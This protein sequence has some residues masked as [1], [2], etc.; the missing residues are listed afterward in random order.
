M[1]RKTLLA[2][3][4]TLCASGQAFAASLDQPLPL[5]GP[6]PDAATIQAWQDR[7]FGMFIH[8][9]IFS[10]AG[11]MWNGKPID[12]GY[13]EQIFANG[14]LPADQY[15][16][17]AKQFDPVNFD[18]DAVAGLA[19]AAGMKFIVITAKHH[20]G[21]NMFKTGQTDY[22]VVDGTPYGKD[23]VKQLAAA[24]ARHGLAFGVYY[25]SIDWHHPGG[26][27]YIEGNSNPITPGQEAFN[28]A[29]LKELLGN[30]GPISEIWFDMGKPTP[31]QSARFARTVHDLQ[32]QTMVS[33]RVWNYQGDFTVM[34]DNAE[35]GV[36]VEEPWQSPASM[37]PDTWG[38]RSWQVRDNLKG[39]IEEQIARLVRV[40]SHG[41]NYI[42]NIGPEGDGSVVPY[43]A[44]V[45]KGMGAWMKVNSQAV[46][47]TQAQPFD[48]L[49]FGYATVGK[50]TLY[51]FIDKRPADG[52]L[53]LP[54]LVDT[55]LVSARLLGG[56]GTVLPVATDA[57]GGTVDISGVPAGGFMPVIAVTFDG[58]L[59]VRPDAVAAGSNGHV[60]LTEKQA[61]HFL[62]YNG[63]GY[64]A[65]DTLYKLRWYAAAPAGHYTVDIRYRPL[66]RMTKLDLT[67]DGHRKTVRLPRAGHAVVRMD[68]DMTAEPYAMQVELT[69]VA[70][71]HKGD[72]LPVSVTGI[73]IA[74]VKGKVP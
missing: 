5:A 54:R 18:A 1:I 45:L 49:D 43:E 72:I 25:S 23:I 24:C 9:G 58:G 28:V 51:L 39:K 33:G 63:E 22:N 4:L 36:A 13:S 57:Q 55:H 19:Q 67:I 7:K 73:D 8:F 74:P 17:L 64:G 66:A 12:N 71:F 47:A 60:A 29:Q 40:V 69:P 26:N 56:E 3:L 10:V 42:L 62:N 35:P 20:D 68:R 59:H 41:G 65:P 46:Y 38:Y 61:A 53:R 34:G 70:P 2:V 21:F 31:A 37:F 15:A 30:Y 48:A 6:R 11:G 52:I 50:S 14:N 44:D 32:P 27:T 16:A